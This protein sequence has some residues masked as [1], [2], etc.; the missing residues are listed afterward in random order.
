MCEKLKMKKMAASMVLAMALS[1]TA[2]N[3]AAQEGRKVLSNP[4]PAYPEMAKRFR[5]EGVVKVQVVIG[6]DGRIKETNVVGGHPL[7]VTSVEE[8]L[9]NWKYAPASSETTA[10]LEFRFHP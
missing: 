7:L 9:K 4:T 6:T 5:L 2:V 1:T 8:T 10:L 3:L